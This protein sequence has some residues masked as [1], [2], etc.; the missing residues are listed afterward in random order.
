MKNEKVVVVFCGPAA[1]GR[2][3]LAFKLKRYLAWLGIP[4]HMLSE[5]PIEQWSVSR[6][7][8]LVAPTP[9]PADKLASKVLAWLHDHKSGVAILNHPL[10]NIERAGLLKQIHGQ[11]ETFCCEVLSDNEKALGVIRT[12][13]A[14]QD[15]NEGFTKN[16]LEEAIRQGSGRYHH[17][18]D[19]EG[20]SYLSTKFHLFGYTRTSLA[21]KPDS[22]LAMLCVQYL[23]HVTLGLFHFFLASHEFDQYTH[24]AHRW[25]ARLVRRFRN[26]VLRIICATDPVSRNV[27]DELIPEVQRDF[28]IDVREHGFHHNHALRINCLAP[29]MEGHSESEAQALVVNSPELERAY[30]AAGLDM[31]NMLCHVS[32]RIILEVQEKWLASL[33]SG[34]EIVKE[35]PHGRRRRLASIVLD[36]EGNE[37]NTLIIGSRQV[38]S[39]ILEGYVSQALISAPGLTEVEQSGSDQYSATEVN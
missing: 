21:L 3:L 26:R 34:T 20:W 32:E 27:M 14:G 4:L 23:K 10:T 37:E 38:L 5:I 15:G 6:S 2:T 31:E 25:T 30:K 39:L 33:P 7:N 12:L 18:T 35:T 16:M 17:L 36:V 19:G 9:V 8:H 11:A 24:T 22:H 28:S 29:R 13:I 1:E